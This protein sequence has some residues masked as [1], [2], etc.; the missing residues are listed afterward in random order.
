MEQGE[1][2]LGRGGDDESLKTGNAG[3]REACGVIGAF[4]VHYEAFW[5]VHAHNFQA[6]RREVKKES[7][8]FG[9]IGR[10]FTLYVRNIML[11]APVSAASS[12][13]V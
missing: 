8:L 4:S 13:L 7:R 2:D 1:D 3:A 6:C 9:I 12:V 11:S 10:I 5:V